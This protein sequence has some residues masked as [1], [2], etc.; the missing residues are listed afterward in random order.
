MWC[1]NLKNRQGWSNPSKPRKAA[2]LLVA[3]QPLHYGG[4]G[5]HMVGLCPWVMKMMKWEGRIEL[6]PWTGVVSN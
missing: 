1:L 2:E 5:S 3:D 6:G 4:M